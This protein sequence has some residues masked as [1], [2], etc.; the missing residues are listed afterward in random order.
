VSNSIN[1]YRWERFV[2]GKVHGG[3][4]YGETLDQ[5]RDWA[6]ATI[7]RPSISDECRSNLELILN[8]EPDLVGPYLGDWHDYQELLRFRMELWR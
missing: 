3:E 6:R 7:L 1:I 5:A 2:D 4:V 8:E